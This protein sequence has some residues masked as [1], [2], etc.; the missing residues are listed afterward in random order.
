MEIFLSEIRFPP[1]DPPKREAMV[2]E[3]MNTPDSII[4]A[5][6]GDVAEIVRVACAVESVQRG[7]AV[8]PHDPQ[9]QARAADIIL[10]GV[11][12]QMREVR[13]RESASR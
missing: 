7:I 3:D 5:E 4:L 13:G 2:N 10:S 12:A 11:G 8:S 9:V 1:A 6:I